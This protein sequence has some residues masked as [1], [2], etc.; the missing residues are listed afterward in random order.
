M[1]WLVLHGLF[2]LGQV[3]EAHLCLV[4]KMGVVQTCK[5]A[6]GGNLK[7]MTIMASNPILKHIP[8]RM[9][10]RDSNKYLHPNVHSNTPNDNQKK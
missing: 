4:Y 9:E 5:K 7:Q 2:N 6:V 8:Q 10:N 1:S 3:S